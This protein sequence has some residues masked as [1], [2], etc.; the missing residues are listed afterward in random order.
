[1]TK[2]TRVVITHLEMT[3]PAQ[4]LPSARRHPAAVIQQVGVP[5]PEFN[6]FFYT[7]VGGEWHWHERLSWSYARWL[8]WLDRSEQETWVVYLHG[9]PAGYVELESQPDGSVEIAY[10]G[11]LPQ[12]IGQGLG[13]QLLTHAI[14]RGWE[15]GA[16]RVW[17]HTCTLDHPRALTNYQA[18]GLQ[19][20][21]EEE[22]WVRLPEEPTGPWPDA[23]RV[24][25]VVSDPKPNL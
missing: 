23:Q 11:L 10:F 19:I 25:F 20:F 7:A 24:P 5:L 18:R 22:K 13:G 1:M 8:T 16:R 14:R 4:F 21:K 3:D 17:V 6:R 9:A 15:W 2:L 12:F